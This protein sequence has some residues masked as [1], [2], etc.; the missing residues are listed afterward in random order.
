MSNF[1]L[2][3]FN[4]HN[5]TGNH[6]EFFFKFTNNVDF[7]FKTLEVRE[8]KGDS[9]DE[10][11]DVFFDFSNEIRSITKKERSRDESISN[12]D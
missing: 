4:A 10:I 1:K 7:I 5:I 2:E 9:P 8:F 3:Y 6:V 11:A 12:S